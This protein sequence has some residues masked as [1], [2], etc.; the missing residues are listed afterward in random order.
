MNIPL[1]NSDRFGMWFSSLISGVLFTIN[2]SNGIAMVNTSTIA[3]QLDIETCN[4]R[5]STVELGPPGHGRSWVKNLS[6]RIFFGR[7]SARL[8]LRFQTTANLICIGSF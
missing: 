2:S 5:D 3:D 7:N 6:P 8:V 1:F 4:E